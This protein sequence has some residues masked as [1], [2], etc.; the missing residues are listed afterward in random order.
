MS[1]INIGVIIIYYSY[2][3]MFYELYDHYRHEKF[4]WG[5]FNL[6]DLHR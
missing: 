1:L 6:Q 4:K 5:P 2:D 3:G